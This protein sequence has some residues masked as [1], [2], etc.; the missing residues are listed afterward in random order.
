M[1]LDLADISPEEQALL[2]NAHFPSSNDA[3]SMDFDGTT[4]LTTAPDFYTN[5]MPEYWPAPHG[6]EPVA[7]VDFT[8]GTA[9][10]IPSPPAPCPAPAPGPALGPALNPA[11]V[12]VPVPVPVPIP[13]P[14][15]DPAPGSDPAPGLDPAPA[16]DP[17]PGLGPDPLPGIPGPQAG[18][19]NPVSLAHPQPASQPQHLQPI[20]G[21]PGPLRASI[22]PQ[23]SIATFGTPGRSQAPVNPP[24]P[25]PAVVSRAGSPFPSSR[26]GTPS[27][28]TSRTRASTPFRPPPSVV[29]PHAPTPLR[30]AMPRTPLSGPSRNHRLTANPTAVGT[31]TRARSASPRSSAC[32]TPLAYPSQPRPLL[33]TTSRLTPATRLGTPCPSTPRPEINP[34]SPPQTPVICTPP[35][36]EQVTMPDSNLNQQGFE[37]GAARENPDWDTA[38]HGGDIPA[39]PPRVLRVRTPPPLAQG[40][41]PTIMQDVAEYSNQPISNGAPA[42]PI[43]YKSNVRPTLAAP[44]SAE[45]ARARADEITTIRDVK[46]TKPNP[47]ASRIKGAKKI[48]AYTGNKPQLMAVMKASMQYSFTTMAPWILLDSTLYSRATEFAKKHTRFPVD[49]MLAD[50]EVIQSLKGKA[51]QVRAAPL[52]PVKELVQEEF[53][54]SPGD[55]RAAKWLQHNARYLYPDFSMQERADQFD[56]TLMAKVIVTLY[57]RSSKRLGIIYMDNVLEEDNP[58]VLAQLLSMVASPSEQ[59]TPQVLEILDRSPEALRGP[60]LAAIAFAAINI[61]HALERLKISAEAKAESKGKK[62][63]K[64][65]KPKVEFS[66]GAYNEMWKQYVRELATHPRLGQIRSGFLDK[67]KEEYCNQVGQRFEKPDGSDHMW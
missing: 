60:S 40:S 33:R 6:P 16:P 7:P 34:V 18:P 11:P 32:N 29:K 3:F 27:A 39:L 56:T 67:L 2:M 51:S 25:V 62:K 20:L 59:G 28:P 61:H 46:K 57:F 36:H 45:F 30:A 44:T 42:C 54:V 10:T 48:A 49:A 17:A 31:P 13:V 22:P 9:F 53:G 21:S 41:G 63:T 1:D 19:T 58:T 12:P 37:T 50:D 47:E 52:D 43:G 15:P 66:E 23:S 64:D 8:S 14:G 65:G 26:L 5:S 24:R 4:G 35:A 55:S 38:N